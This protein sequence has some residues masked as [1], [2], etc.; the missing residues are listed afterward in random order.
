MEARPTES[1]R[2]VVT[3]GS[4][5]CVWEGGLIEMAL[6]AALFKSH[7]DERTQHTQHT[8]TCTYMRTREESTEEAKKN[9]EG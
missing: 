9:E 1:I 6:A 8:Y 3:L 4:S 2:C 5:V 7:A